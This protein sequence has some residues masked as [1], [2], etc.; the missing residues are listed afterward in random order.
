MFLE[1]N[2]THVLLEC[3]DQFI[4]VIIRLWTILAQGSKTLTFILHPYFYI[5]TILA[6]SSKTLTY[7]LHPY[8]YIE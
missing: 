1:K 7:I 4:I 5:W 6:Q 3:F 2:H 8:F